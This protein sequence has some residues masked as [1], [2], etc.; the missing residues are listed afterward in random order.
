MQSVA[1]EPDRVVERLKFLGLWLRRPASLG[2]VAPSSREL[3][4]A[5]AAEINPERPGSVVEL[6]GGTGSI[7]AALRDAIPDP[8]QLLV[9]EKEPRLCRLLSARFPDTRIVQGDAQLLAA[10]LTET[11]TPQ[12]KVIVSSLPL[13]SLPSAV[14]RK[15][16]HEC[17]DVLGEDGMLVQFTYGPL[18]PIPRDLARRLAIRGERG[19]WVLENLPPATVW[20]FRRYKSPVEVVAPPEDGSTAGAPEPTARP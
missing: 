2:A 17:F 18:S 5:M 1:L 15:I 7:T 3:A 8:T 16:V 9:V 20:R 12:V 19:S 11:Q 6:G 4:Q 13:L 10:L 14:C